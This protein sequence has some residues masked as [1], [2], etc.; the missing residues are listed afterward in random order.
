MLDDKVNY[1]KMYLRLFNAVS[2]ATE[3]LQKAIQD[4]EDDYIE[5]AKTTEE[6][7]Y[8]LCDEYLKE[9]GHPIPPEPMES[10]HDW[11]KEF[12]AMLTAVLTVCCASHPP[13]NAETTDKSETSC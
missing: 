11:Q 6:A 7:L 9:C 10:A 3:I 4:C 12:H 1:K 13:K 2:D 8:D 5:N